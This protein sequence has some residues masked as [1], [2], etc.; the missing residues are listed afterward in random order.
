[1]KSSNRSWSVSQST[2]L[3]K[4]PRS[5]ER[6]LKRQPRPKT[7]DKVTMRAPSVVE[8]AVPHPRRTTRV[9]V[10][11]KSKLHQEEAPVTS[12]APQTRR[13]SM[14]RVRR[15]KVATAD[16]PPSR[17]PSSQT[18]RTS[19][20]RSS[21]WS[22]RAQGRIIVVVIQSRLERPANRITA[23]LVARASRMRRPA[24]NTVVRTDKSP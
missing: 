2:Q 5:R 17:S 22:R 21:P 7:S 15:Q 18:H 1:M 8:V 23:T 4:K 9:A 19:S 14:R 10:T 11:R 6:R 12:R 13:A 20:R 3:K 16:A 24:P